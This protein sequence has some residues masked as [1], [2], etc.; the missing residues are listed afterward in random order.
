MD[1]ITILGFFA[2]ICTT[3]AFL[4][5]ALKVHKTRHTGDLSLGMLAIF[6]LGVIGWL[7]YGIF[8]DDIVIISANVVTLF[9][10]GYILAMKIKLG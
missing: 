3:L 9:L 2:A 5:Q 7:L 8:R 6:T 10:T 1:P 4:P